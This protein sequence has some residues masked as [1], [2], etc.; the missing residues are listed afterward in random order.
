M[1]RDQL[2]RVAEVAG[3]R[4]VLDRLVDRV[5]LAIPSRRAAVKLGSEPRTGA[6]QLMAQQFGEQVVIAVPLALGI[7]RDDERVVPLQSSEQPLGVRVSG[8]RGAQR[9]RKPLEDRALD[10][11]L[12]QLRRLAVEDLESEVVDDLLVVPGEGVDE[13]PVVLAAPQ[14]QAGEL[15]PGRPPLRPLVQ[16]RDLVGLEVKPDHIVQERA[17][18]GDVEAQVGA[19]DLG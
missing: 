11:E 17:R 1:G 6:R 14:R 4:R 10:H 5:G 19:T 3:R 18:L 13:L 15:K 12:A 9:P 8:H 2:D 16:A 7:Q